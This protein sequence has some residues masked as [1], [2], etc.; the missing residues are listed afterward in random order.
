MKAIVGHHEMADD[1][2]WG[3]V[4]EDLIN[5]GMLNAVRDDQFD[6]PSS[7]ATSYSASVTNSPLPEGHP[8]S[9]P[10][11]AQQQFSESADKESLF[12]KVKNT[13]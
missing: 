5:S 13:H 12:Y 2:R 6:G 8:G 4:E 3:E 9:I 7:S 1:D 11:E 10:D